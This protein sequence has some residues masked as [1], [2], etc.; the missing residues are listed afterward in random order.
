VARGDWS[1]LVAEVRRRP[2]WAALVDEA[3]NRVE[4]FVHHED[5]RRAQPGW[6]PRELPEE[7]SAALWSRVRAQAKFVLRKTPATITVTAPRFGAVTAGRGGPD[8]DL[9]GP[10]Q[11]LL[12]YLVGRQDHA[13]VEVAGPDKITS[14]MQRARFGI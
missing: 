12:L 4:Y 1:K 11:E 2:W 8:V 14:R 5:V 7:F 13:R 10:P 3:I 6:E 9:V